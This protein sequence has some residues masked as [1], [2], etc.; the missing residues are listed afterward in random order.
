MTT[1]KKASLV[2]SDLTRVALRET[3][4][5]L[6]DLRGANLTGWSLRR[7]NL[8]GTIMDRAQI[9]FLVCELGIQIL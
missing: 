6:T 8:K 7:H 4:F 5:D 3:V 1:L 2:E 9:E